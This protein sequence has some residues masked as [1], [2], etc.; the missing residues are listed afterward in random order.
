MYAAAY[1]P[2]LLAISQLLI[3]LSVLSV[4]RFLSLAAASCRVTT[5]VCRH[6][7]FVERCRC[8]GINNAFVRRKR[9]IILLPL[10]E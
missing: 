9:D 2:T 8:D 4:K 10:P 7:G 5:S 1:S 6:D 3:S